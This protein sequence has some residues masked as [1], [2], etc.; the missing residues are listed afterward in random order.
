M[1]TREDER[2]EDIYSKCPF[3]WRTVS[4]SETDEA[5]EKWI[6]FHITRKLCST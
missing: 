2:P 1:T 5:I 3:C 4:R 6:E